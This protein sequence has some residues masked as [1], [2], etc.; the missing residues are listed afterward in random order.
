MSPSL[1]RE[2]LAIHVEMIAA[3]SEVG[4][5]ILLI[6]LDWGRTDAS[7]CR[8]GKTIRDLQEERYSDSRIDDMVSMQSSRCVT[9]FLEMRPRYIPS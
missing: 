2:T 8:A 6:R 7:F 5:V 3:N 4:R 9:P 1:D